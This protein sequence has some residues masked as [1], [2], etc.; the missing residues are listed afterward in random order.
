MHSDQYNFA[1]LG[2]TGNGVEGN[3]FSTVREGIRAQIQHLKCY[4][5]TE[6]LNQPCVDQR[7]YEW[8]RGTAPTVEELSQK[9]AVG[10]EYGEHILNSISRLKQY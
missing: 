9:W 4:A 10:S 8:L 6:P 1:G 7:W 5:S 2:A 3:R